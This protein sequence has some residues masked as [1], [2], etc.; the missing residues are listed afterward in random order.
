MPGS[1]LIR[2]TH[3]RMST[4]EPLGHNSSR[5]CAECEKCAFVFALLSAFNSP[6]EVWSI[7]G[8]DLFQTS[9]ASARFNELLGVR[10]VTRLPDG[11]EF[12]GRQQ[13]SH[14]KT[15]PEA[16][17][18]AYEDG[19]DALKPQSSSCWTACESA[20]CRLCGSHHAPG[21]RGDWLRARRHPFA[22]GN[23]D[24]IALD[25]HGGDEEE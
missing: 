4:H 21:A 6:P 5:W 20:A 19:H 2:A 3:R 7:F 10:G 11:R 25:E 12:P 24:T 13:L 8:D 1:M 14:L 17:M 22:A 9:T 18:L 15:G 16:A 23:S